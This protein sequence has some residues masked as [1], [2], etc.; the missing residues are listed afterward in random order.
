MQKIEVIGRSI[1]GV[2]DP[3]YSDGKAKEKSEGV[4]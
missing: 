1:F 4:S 3:E 2:A